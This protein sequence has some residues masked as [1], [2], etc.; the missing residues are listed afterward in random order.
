[1]LCV[2]TEIRASSLSGRGLFVLE[3][4]P[5]GHIVG[6]LGHDAPV[7]SEDA[8]L[9]RLRTDD[10]VFALTSVRWVGR[11]FLYGNSITHEEYINHSFEPSMLY[12]CG[13]CFARRD[14]VAGEELTADYVYF[15]SESEEENF[16]DS[17]SGL[18]VRGISA[19][20]ALLRSTRELLSILEKVDY[21]E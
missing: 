19:R 2:K 10:A 8:Y 12:H 11:H 4:V 5:A 17:V 6:I 18:P 15:L 14:I 1:M 21:V 7:I 9:E 3:D 13:I 16:I 20:E